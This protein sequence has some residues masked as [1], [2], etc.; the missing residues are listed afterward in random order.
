MLQ[1]ETA[2]MRLCRFDENRLGLVLGE[3]IRDVTQA[4][5]VLPAVRWPLPRGDLMIASL[6][7]LRAR[8]EAIAGTAPVVA[9]SA[10]RLLSP[11]ANPRKIIAAPVNYQLHLDEARADPG[12]HFGAQVKTIDEYGLFLKATSSLAG[13]DEGVVVGRTQRRID[14]EV[15]LAVIIGP[16][17]RNIAAAD[18]LSHIAGYTIGLDMSVR[19]TEDRSYRKSLDTFTVLGPHLVTADEIADPGALDVELSVNGEV[20]QASN[21]RNLIYSIPMLIAYA[22]AAYTL[23]AGDAILTGTPEGVG[24]VR[25]GDTMSA[26]I[27]GI[28]RMDVAVRGAP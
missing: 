23:D 7:A 28:G 27:E 26:R 21:T 24:P 22:S 11:V 20:R 15:E 25:P 5:D 8:I 14:H 12:I 6:A 13:C 16:G 18:A 3:E 4:L 10:I 19:G 9:R 2:D 1:S 17:G